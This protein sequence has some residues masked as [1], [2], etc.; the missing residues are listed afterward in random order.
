MKNLI[1]CSNF[2]P[3][4]KEEPFLR[5]EFPFLESEFEHIFIHRN[6]LDTAM[7]EGHSMLPKT[8]IKVPIRN[9]LRQNWKIL[10]SA[11]LTEFIQSS[12]RLHYIVHYKKYFNIWIGWLKEAKDWEEILKQFSSNDTII[13]TYWYEKQAN[14]LS[15]LKA[16]GKLPFR[17]VSRAHGWDLDKNQRTDGLI[18][19]RHW[20][21]KHAPNNLVSISNF[22][23]AIFKENYGVIANVA[24]L[25]TT[26]LGLGPVPSDNNKLTII[27]NSSIIP[28]KRV[29][30]IIEILAKSK[31]QITW[32]HYGDGPMANTLAWRSLP[33][34]VTL[35]RKGNTHHTALLQELITT[36]VDIMLHVSELEGIPVSI[37]ECMSMG[38]PVMA[39]DTGGVKEIVDNENGWLLPI[40]LNA[41]QIAE[42]IDNLHK[43]K[44]VLV[45]KRKMARKKW[46]DE[47]QAK[48]NFPNFIQT[49]LSQ[50]NI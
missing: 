37:M 11:V 4:D 47:Y 38:I 30:L 41:A 35:I 1:L 48:V 34:N 7:D 9:L 46:E 32:I 31:T 21:L 43:T 29:D 5:T 33:K 36:P 16:Q 18:P 28:L 44:A 22:G 50:R 24:R 39:C 45:E 40:T 15:V 42:K 8:I 49:Y 3:S 13:Y 27:S 10:L 19:F 2:F 17:W 25:G 14:A 20:M 26:D 23:S 6:E 12:K